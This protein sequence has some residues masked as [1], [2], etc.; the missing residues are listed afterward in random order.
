MALP[1]VGVGVTLGVG[2][3]VGVPVHIQSVSLGQEGFLQTPA[4]VQYPVLHCSSAWHEALQ[5]LKV[6][7]GV[8][9]G[10]PVQ[11]ESGHFSYLLL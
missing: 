6:P 4:L 3:G 5:T 7:V 10:V 9:V 11:R 8:G 2:V 1:G